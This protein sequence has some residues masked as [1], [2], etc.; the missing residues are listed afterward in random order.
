MNR[1]EA[2][3]APIIDFQFKCLKNGLNGIGIPDLIVAQNAKQN[4]SKIYFDRKDS[5]GCVPGVRYALLCGECAQIDGRKHSGTSHRQTRSGRSCLRHIDGV[6]RYTLGRA[7]NRMQPTAALRAAAG[8]S[9][10]PT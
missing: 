5:G 2:S 1:V 6:R 10:E 8:E 7:N 9:S 4:S 3:P